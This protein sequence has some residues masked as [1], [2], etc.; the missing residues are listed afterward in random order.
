MAEYD[1]HI[2]GGT[3]V[4]GTRVPRFKGDLWIKDGTISKI[5]GRAD[6]VAIP[7]AIFLKIAKYMVKLQ[8]I[9]SSTKGRASRAPFAGRFL[10]FLPC[11][12]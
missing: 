12:F 3:I 9:A 8:K 10:Y 5:G 4:D 1:I 6:G 2:A 7:R 11:F